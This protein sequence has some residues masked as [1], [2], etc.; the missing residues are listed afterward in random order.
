M[1]VCNVH[2][3]LLHVK[4]KS[5]LESIDISWRCC[6]RLKLM[7]LWKNVELL[8]P[9]INFQ[10]DVVFLKVVLPI[11]ARECFIPH[12]SI[13]ALVLKK[14]LYHFFRN[15]VFQWYRV[16]IVLDNRNVLVLWLVDCPTTIWFN[17][18]FLHLL[19]TTQHV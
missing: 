6:L 17:I 16:F 4:G 13:L 15:D 3:L 19:S 2:V 10:F 5:V 1:V 18:T 7:N 12:I 9:R 14:N 11:T 8:A